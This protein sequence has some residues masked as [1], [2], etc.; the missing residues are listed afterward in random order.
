MYFTTIISIHH[1]HLWDIGILSFQISKM[2]RNYT[3]FIK[4]I[5][6]TLEVRVVFRANA[7]IVLELFLCL[8]QYSTC[9]SNI[10]T[11]GSLTH[12][13]SMRPS[14]LSYNGTICKALP[15][16]LTESPAD[17]ETVWRKS[18]RCFFYLYPENLHVSYYFV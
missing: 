13:T 7:R 15:T 5:D 16:S 9:K 17:S 8:L 4:Y 10:L 1:C 11:S 14:C 12:W 3:Y 2:I 18:C 6:K